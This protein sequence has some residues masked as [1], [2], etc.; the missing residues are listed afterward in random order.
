VDT[1]SAFEDP[2][3]SLSLGSSVVMEF[4]HQDGRVIPVLLPQRSLLIMSKEARYWHSV[5]QCPNYFLQ[6]ML[7]MLHT[8]IL[9]L[10][11]WQQNLRVHHCLYKDTLLDL[12]LICFRIVHVLQSTS[13]R[14]V[15]ICRKLIMS[16]IIEF[17]EGSR[18]NKYCMLTFPSSLLI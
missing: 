13:S 11:L 16:F 17:C 5:T 1:H 10:I 9:I 6:S 7:H 12:I 15:L 18:P 4:R 14:S 8:S 2:I 3:L